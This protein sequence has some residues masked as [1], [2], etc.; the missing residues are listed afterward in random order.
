MVATAA[1]AVFRDLQLEQVPLLEPLGFR[2]V[3]RVAR[4]EC[5]WWPPSVSRFIVYRIEIVCVDFCKQ[6]LRRPCTW[7]PEQ[8]LVRK[9][10]HQR[11]LAALK[12]LARYRSKAL[13]SVLR[14]AQLQTATRATDLRR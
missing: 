4:I 13:A 10:F 11:G 14:Y 1:R 2:G 3:T 8:A 5:P 12:P 6:H 9:R 7:S